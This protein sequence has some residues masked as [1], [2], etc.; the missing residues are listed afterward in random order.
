MS[1]GEGDIIIKGGSVKI[2]F[3]DTLYPTQSSNRN[4][5]QNDNRRI[6]QIRVLDVN[7]GILY[8]T[9]ENNGGLDYEVRV[10]TN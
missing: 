3:D 2:L 4:D 8:S 7:G 10:T 1:E 6:T 9:G 5:H